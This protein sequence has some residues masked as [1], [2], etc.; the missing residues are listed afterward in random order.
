MR[1][2]APAETTTIAHCSV[3]VTSVVVCI[4]II[5]LMIPPGTFTWNGLRSAAA[6]IHRTC[7]M[8]D[9]GIQT[10]AE[11]Y[12]HAYEALYMQVLIPLN[13]P[14]LTSSQSSYNYWHFIAVISLRF[15]EYFFLSL[16]YTINF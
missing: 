13:S 6:S 15:L 5:H 11:S 1:G 14:Q 12:T 7:L 10:Y 9:T 4:F 8:D 16:N 3:H 2:S